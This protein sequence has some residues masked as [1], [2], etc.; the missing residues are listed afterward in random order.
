M[1]PFRLPSHWVEYAHGPGADDKQPAAVELCNLITAKDY[2]LIPADRVDLVKE[3]VDV[4]GLYVG[5]WSGDLLDRYNHTTAIRIVKRA[6][7]WLQEAA[8]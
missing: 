3:V 8:S 1:K 7:K 6:Q 2:V 5:G 4:A